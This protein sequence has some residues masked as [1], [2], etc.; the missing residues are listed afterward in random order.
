FLLGALRDGQVGGF[1]PAK[2]AIDIAGRSGE[3]FR[4]IRPIKRQPADLHEE[5]VGIDRRHAAPRDKSNDVV[6]QRVGRDVG[7]EENAAVAT[8]GKARDGTIDVGKVMDGVIDRLDGKRR[9][10]RLGDAPVMNGIGIVRIVDQ[11]NANDGGRNLLQYFERLAE[12]R[13][14]ESGKPGD[15][16]PRP[17]QALRPADADRIARAWQHHWDGASEPHQD[18]DDPAARGDDDVG[19]GSHQTCRVAPYHVHIVGGPTLLELDIPAVRPSQLCQLLLECANTGFALAITLG[20]RHYDS[21]APHATWPLC[22]RGERPDHRR[23]PDQ[24]DELAPVR[25]RVHSITSSAVI[26]G[27]KRYGTPAWAYSGL[28][29]VNFTTLPHFSVSSAI[30]FPK[31]AGDIGAGTT[32]SSLKRAFILGSASP[33]LISLFSLSTISAGVLFG[34]PMP[35]QTVASYPARKSPTVGTSGRASERIAAVTASGRNLPALICSIEEGKVSN[36]ICTCPPTKSIRAGP[37]PR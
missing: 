22:A 10:R 26:R 13:Q 4:A 18:R 8:I 28:I 12:H 19:I 3:P 15:V 34:A 5:R 33:A 23:A 25:P 17:R 1:S 9:G 31:S 7:Q 36:M 30:I 11:R 16:A 24:C 37:A 29:P 2:K 32:P 21:N 20:E 27:T 35:H 14:L 6:A